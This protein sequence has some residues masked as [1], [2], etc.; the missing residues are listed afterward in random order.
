VKKK[1]IN[2][3]EEVWIENTDDYFQT[4]KNIFNDEGIQSL[5]NDILKVC[6][7]TIKG[8]CQMEIKN[9]ID[10]LI[11]LFKLEISQDKEEKIFNT[12]LILS[13]KEMVYEI[14]LVTSLFIENMRLSKSKIWLLIREIIN[15]PEQLNEELSLKGYINSLKEYNIDIDFL[16]EPGYYLNILMLLK[17]NPDLINFLI[18]ITEN[19]FNIL[20]E[21]LKYNDNV[22]LSINDIKDFKELVNFMNH[23]GEMEDFKFF[24]LLQKETEKNKAINLYFTKYAYNY[25]ELKN[26]FESSFNELESVKYKI[27]CISLNS[28][29]FLKNKEGNFFKGS[30]FIQN[31]GEIHEKNIDISA[32]KDLRCYAISYKNMSNIPEDINNLVIYKKFSKEINSICEIYNII[33]ELY[34]TGYFKEIT[35]EITFTNFESN[36]HNYL[37]TLQSE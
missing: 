28:K 2:E 16:N 15:N 31:M 13:K 26:L 30:Y 4:I 8:K 32:L 21:K 17:K 24:K 14:A 23:F 3:E 19:D 25:I 33:Q 9:E 1:F 10:I 36:Y 6:L 37:I 7:N 22:F 18:G 12:F 11:S 27:N 20:E 34:S 29:F 5:D 35:I